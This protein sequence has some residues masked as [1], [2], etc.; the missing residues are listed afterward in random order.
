MS[1]RLP[2]VVSA[3]VTFILLGITGFLIYVAQMVALNGVIDESKAFTSIGLSVACQGLTILFASA[4]A[5]WFANTLIMKFDWNRALAVIAAVIV[6]TLL[7]A[8]IAL[9]STVISIPLAGIR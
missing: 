9:I 3:L 1:D 4:F 2:V 7:G 6:A 5:G 8:S